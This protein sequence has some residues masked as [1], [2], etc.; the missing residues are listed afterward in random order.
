MV[1]SIKMYIVNNNSDVCVELYLYTYD[2]ST[3]L[4]ET[5]SRN[6]CFNK[7]RD[8]TTEVLRLVLQK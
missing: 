5:C 8:Q 6:V 4:H 7:N 2:L 3:L 1:C